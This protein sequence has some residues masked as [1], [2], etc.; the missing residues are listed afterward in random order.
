MK[1]VFIMIGFLSLGLGAVG[2]V[3]PVLPTTPFL[4]VSAFCF[5]KS[6][7]RLNAWFKGTGLYK[8][9]LESFVRGRGM[10]WGTKLRIMVTVTVLMAAGFMA[11]H[12]TVVGRICLAAVWAG[13]IVAFVFFIK[14]CPA[15][16]AAGAWAAAVAV[17]ALAPAPAP[18]P[19]PVPA[20]VPAPAPVPGEEEGDHSHD[21]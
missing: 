19:A 15:E 1:I 9:H 11:M 18:A 7:A 12:N 14:T 5:A 17:P 2:V 20:P 13:H 6:S 10:T 21:D 8:R 16:A 3:L 4:L